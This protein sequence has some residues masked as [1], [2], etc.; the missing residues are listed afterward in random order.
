MHRLLEFRDKTT[1]CLRRYNITVFF[2]LS[3]PYKS[4]VIQ[5]V[6]GAAYSHV[7]VSHNLL[8]I[9]LNHEADKIRNYYLIYTIRTFDPM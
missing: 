3:C 2:D 8:V 5:K 7:L 6:S 4:P 1:E 9:S